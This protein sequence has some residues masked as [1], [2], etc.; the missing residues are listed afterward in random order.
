MFQLITIV[1]SFSSVPDIIHSKVIMSAEFHEKPARNIAIN[2]N[3]FYI[4]I[5]PEQ[6]S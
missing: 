2:C 3:A 1:Q 4:N 5:G 6:A